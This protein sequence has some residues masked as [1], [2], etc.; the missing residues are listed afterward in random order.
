MA[1][2]PGGRSA[3]MNDLIKRGKPVHFE[4]G[5]FSITGSKLFDN[6]TEQFASYGVRVEAATTIKCDVVISILNTE[7]TE[8]HS[9]HGLYANMKGGHEE[10]S[11]DIDLPNSPL[12]I[13]FKKGLL[14]A[15]KP[16][17]EDITISLDLDNW[18]GQ[19][20]MFLSYFDQLCQFSKLIN[21]GNKIQFTF[22]HQGNQILQGVS[23]VTEQAYFIKQILPYIEMLE[24][25]RVI[26]RKFDINP[27]VPKFETMTQ[28]D[29]ESLAVIRE[30]IEKGEHRQRNAGVRASAVL[31]AGE[32]MASLVQDGRFPGDSVTFNQLKGCAYIFG[33]EVENL[34]LSHQLTKVG[35]TDESRQKL[36]Q[37]C[38]GDEIELEWEGL[39][40]S[41]YITTHFLRENPE[42]AT[43]DMGQ[44][45]ITE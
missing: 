14:L 22:I 7:N 19:R 36:A 44:R 30:I 29:A 23:N 2:F 27:V 26:S 3:K 13:K 38:Q 8:I 17:K 43:P 21:I 40:G 31:V 18:S 10:L 41:E 28:D 32:G 5:E 39:E 45:Q 20:L 34:C 25:A 12:S 11:V 37:V 4:P 16:E 6:L 9:I 15:E 35:L 1:Q 33:T 42:V 24:D